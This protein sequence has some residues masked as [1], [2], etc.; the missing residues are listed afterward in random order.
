MNK[1]AQYTVIFAGAFV[2][3][4]L[5]GILDLGL[6]VAIGVGVA[7]GVSLMLVLLAVQ[8]KRGPA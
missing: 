3:G 6:L 5:I 8:H 1:K 7:V 2:A 4:I